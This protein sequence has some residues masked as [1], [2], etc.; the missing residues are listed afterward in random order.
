MKMR[1][2]PE[3]DVIYLRFREGKIDESD[4]IKSGLIIDY[5]AEG[6]PVAI[7]ILNAK[8]ILAG[9]PELTVDFSLS[10][11]KTKTTKKSTSQIK[12]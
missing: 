8:E 3:A 10:G 11:S 12:S 2:D 4:E 9:R 1:Y 5:D 6:R 7:E